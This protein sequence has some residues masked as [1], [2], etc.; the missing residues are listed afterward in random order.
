[1]QLL[2]VDV[3]GKLQAQAQ[4]AAV[5]DSAAI[6]ESESRVQKLRGIRIDSKSLIAASQQRSTKFAANLAEISRESAVE[7]KVRCE[8]Y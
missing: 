7:V 3:I 1:L 5:K 4:P 8:I 6:F 2:I